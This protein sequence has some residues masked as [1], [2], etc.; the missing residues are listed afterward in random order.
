MEQT[1][2][3][4]KAEAQAA[5]GNV[6]DRLMDDLQHIISEAEKWLDDSAD[7][8]EASETRMRFDDALRTAKSDLHKLE[9][10]FLAHSRVVADSVNLYVQEN[11]WKAVGIGVA[12][13]AVIGML[14]ARK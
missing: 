8:P 2:P 6:R 14:L 3:N 1:P 10:S 7:T 4:D 12:V 5:A 13:G 9:D 11:P